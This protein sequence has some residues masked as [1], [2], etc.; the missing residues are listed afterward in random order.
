MTFLARRGLLFY[1]DGSTPKSAAP[2]V[3]LQTDTAFVRGALTIDHVQDGAS[4]DRALSDLETQA[5]SHGSAVGTAFLYPVSVERL[6][7]W[8]RGLSSRGFVLVPASAIV[9]KPK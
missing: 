5:R 7:L 4:I 9:G 3:A 8:A 2:D 6:A 1:D